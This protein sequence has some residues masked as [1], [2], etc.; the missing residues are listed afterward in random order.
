M[1]MEALPGMIDIQPADAAFA[2]ISRESTE[3][4]KHWVMD[5][6]N[7][8]MEL[9]GRAANYITNLEAHQKGVE[10]HCTEEVGRVSVILADLNKTKEDVKGLFEEIKVKID[11]NDQSLQTIPELTQKLNDK[12][13]QIDELFKKTDSLLKEKT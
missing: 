10:Q 13:E 2:G 5:Q 12:T 3:A 11:S 8:R 7:M 4:I 1:A 6:L 9:V